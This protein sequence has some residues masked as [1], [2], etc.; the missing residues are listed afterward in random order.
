M[1]DS[2]IP[3]N[4]GPDLAE[5]R[6]RLEALLSEMPGV[7]VAFSGG[8]DST[9]LLRVAVDVLGE[10]VLAVTGV[11]PAVPARERDE[12]VALASRF[13]VSHRFLD[14][15]ELEREGYV[16][17]GPDRCFHCKTE[18]YEKLEVIRAELGY[19]CVVDGTNASDV[20]DHRPGRRAAE[21]LGVRS[22]LA[23]AGLTKVEVRSISREYELPTA[24]KPAMACLAS[25]FPYGTP[26]TEEGLS[27]VEA[28][29]ESVRELGFR[30]FRVRHHGETARLEIEAADFERLRDPDLRDRL[31]RGIRKAGY[32]FVTVDLEEFRSG[33]LNDVL[34]FPSVDGA[35]SR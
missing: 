5:K 32:R 9:A 1:N 29:E 20:G 31:V 12:A 25:R 7:V 10:R 33:R 22:P 3:S 8:V 35:R 4:P 34:S 15:A 6:R 24:D 28:A 11:S 30:Q 18:L 21:E 19:G 26:V 2:P 16:A 14:T 17:N 13:G 23:E 27:R